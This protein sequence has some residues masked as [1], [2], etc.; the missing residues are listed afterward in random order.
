VKLILPVTPGRQVRLS[1]HRY[2]Q[3]GNLIIIED[4]SGDRYDLHFSDD[5]LLALYD[6]ARTRLNANAD[7]AT[8]REE[9]AS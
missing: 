4:P 5:D 3:V 6:A 8:W 1:P 9:E 7:A 2:G